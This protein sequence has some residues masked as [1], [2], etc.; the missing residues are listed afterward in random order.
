MWP[1]VAARALGWLTLRNSI[2]SPS[3][4]RPM[5][6][7]GGSAS[8]TAMRPHAPLLVC[9]IALGF[10]GCRV[11]DTPV[12]DHRLLDAFDPPLVIGQT[13]REDA[14]LRLGMPLERF[15]NDRILCWRITANDGKQ[16][17]VSVFVSPWYASSDAAPF[18][19]AQLDPRVR[20]EPSQLASL[21]L[22]FDEAGR[23][24]KAKALRQP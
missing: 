14:L 23:L 12:D 24:R 9:G 19:Q 20:I 22:V 16:R 2:T 15:E 3:G 6:D 5:A 18:T 4:D 21:V 17:P 11:A 10:A 8:M 13:T 7:R 1:P